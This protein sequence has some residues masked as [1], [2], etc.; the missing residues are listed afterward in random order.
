MEHL[1]SRCGLVKRR[2]PPCPS[3]A[4]AAKLPSTTGAPSFPGSSPPIPLGAGNA[5]W[6]HPLEL[7]VGNALAELA[8]PSPSALQIPMKMMPGILMYS[9]FSP[10]FL[11]WRLLQV[12]GED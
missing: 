4:K 5:V 2:Q 12:L 7:G 1:R 3:C 9:F 10:S 6:I 11:L 8:S